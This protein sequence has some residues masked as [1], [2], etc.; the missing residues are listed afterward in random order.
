MDKDLWL[1]KGYDLPDG[2]KIKAL[3]YFGGKWQ[4]FET[5]AANN[6][7]L[8]CDEIARKWS[9]FGFLDESIFR[10]ISF[11]GKSFKALIS[12]KKYV[13]SPIE[14]GKSPEDYVDA[15]AFALSL[16]ESRKLS[17]DVSFHDGIYAEQY[18]KLLPLW[19]LTPKV[20]DETVLGTWLTGGVSI[21][22]K[23]FR[24][25]LKLM[26][27]M[28]SADDL[29]NIIDAAGFNAPVEDG[30]YKS[31]SASEDKNDDSAIVKEPSSK[32]LKSHQKTK[33]EKFKLPGRPQLEEFFNERIIDI[34]FNSKKYQALGIDF[35]SAI[36]LHGPPG[37]GKTFAVE[38]LIEFIDLPSY[39]IDSNSIG[40]PYIHETGKK[41]YEIFDKAIDNSPS[42]IVID[43]MESF[44]SDRRAGGSGGLHHVEEVAEFL[45]R[46]PEAVKS[47]V[48]II[49]MT[50]RIEMIDPAILRRGRF[51]HVVEVGMP[52]RQET[53]SL[54]DCLLSKLPK[55]QGLN[56]DKIIDALTGKPLS[57][58]AFVMREAARLSAKSDKTVI[59]QESIDAALKSLP[60]ERAKN[61]I[62]FIR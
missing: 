44:L 47:K 36:V 49:A 48:L 51:D 12:H 35:P 37:C 29:E 25:L 28:M 55:A 27:W 53:A 60:Q 16:R 11:G 52:S 14:N 3:L 19:T 13:L 50:N 2:S 43:E 39:S 1:P 30:M 32:P 34:L 59:D 22:T 7:L 62:G 8:I 21:S 33:D 9:E 6:I 10:E 40:S 38:K 18:S 26:E 46:I 20:D 31:K 61:N 23:S 4:I 17:S 45:R 57:D 54:M 5:D 56:V 15:L 42:V 24:R 58:L 41:I